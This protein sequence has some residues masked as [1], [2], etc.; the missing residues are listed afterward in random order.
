MVGATGVTTR[1][2]EGR[3][4]F[5]REHVFNLVGLKRFDLGKEGNQDI[6][7]GAYYFFRSGQR[8][9]LR[10]NTTLSF[11]GSAETIT[12]TTYVEPRDANQ[13]EDTFN[14]NLNVDWSF[15]IGGSV[16]G[17]VGAEAANVTNE[18]E[19]IVNNIATG[20]PSPGI[21]AFQTPREYR[22]KVGVTF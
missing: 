14:L 7:V 20:Q 22:V 11:P 10:P 21:A 16:R 4:S 19:V 12:T 6:T 9:G 2:R 18:Q 17:K 1:F 3:N 8:W 13:L 15:P 5:D